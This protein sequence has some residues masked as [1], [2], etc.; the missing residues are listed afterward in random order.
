[1]IEPQVAAPPTDPAT[2]AA[3]AE[4]TAARGALEDELVRL[5]ATA[6]AAVPDAAVPEEAS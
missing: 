5:E 6:R 1:M 2:I 4:V 3:L